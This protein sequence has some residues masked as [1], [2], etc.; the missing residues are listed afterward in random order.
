MRLPNITLLILLII[1]IVPNISYGAWIWTPETGSWINPKSAVKD[2]ASE[3]FSWAM[4]FYETRDYKKAMAE[5]HK[6]VNY[7]PNAKQASKAQYYI[8]RSYEDLKELYHA[9]IAYQRV[10][11]AYPYAENRDEIINRQYDIGMLFFKGE[12]ARLLG[13]AV[14]PATDKAIEIFDQVIKNSPYGEYADKAQFRI[15]EAYKNNSAYPEAMLAFQAL[16]E[17]YPRSELLSEANYQI[18]ECAYLAS[19]GASYDQGSTDIAIEKFKGF[20]EEHRD[21]TFS[22][23]AKNTLTKLKE[24]KAQNV[25]ETAQFYEKVG[26]ISSA[27]IYYKEL[28]DNYPDTSLAKT[29]LARLMEIEKI[30]ETRR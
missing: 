13:V 3:Q 23:N 1:L 7:Y 12:K 15:G 4:G 28:V 5:F 17:E 19:L 8:G 10:M 18:A 21:D 20:V 16:V 9:Y 27:A 6:L 24:K 30:I 14:L 25:Y 26:R 29:S 2:T 11:E 22:E